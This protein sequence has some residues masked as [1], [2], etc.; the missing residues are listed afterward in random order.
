MKVGF[1]GAGNMGG[2]IAKAVS[3]CALQ[4]EILLADYSRDKAEELALEIGAVVSD[5]VGVVEACD[6]VFLGVKPQVLG[7]VLQQ[8]APVAAAK[9]GRTV[10]ISMA[11]G[12]TMETILKTLGDGMP[13][14]RIMPN[15]PVSVG[16]GMILFDCSAAVTEEET[17]TFLGIMEKAGR[18]DRLPEHLIDAGCAVSGCGPAFAFLFAEALA[19]GGVTCGLPRQKALEYAAQMLYGAADLLLS[20]GRHPGELKDAV[21]SPGGSTIRGV[22][23]LEESGFRGA[24]M[25][26]VIAAYERTVE[27]G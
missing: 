14:I 23:A 25:D 20:G 22:L 15:M 4:P 13:L 21:C 26:A 8:L 16:S 10:F 5:N 27:L 9:A 1:I 3:K 7:G 6:Y 17:G 19:D 2:A 18:V 11:A 24:V 12:V